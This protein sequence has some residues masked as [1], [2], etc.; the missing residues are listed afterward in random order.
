MGRHSRQLTTYTNTPH[1]KY[2]IKTPQKRLSM[3]PTNTTP[4]THN[5]HALSNHLQLAWSISRPRFWLYLGGTYLVGYSAGI[6]Q[7]TDFST[8]IFWLYLLFFLL[9]ANVFLYGINDYA[10][11][12]KYDRNKMPQLFYPGRTVLQYIFYKKIG[13]RAI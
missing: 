12:D 4:R 9:I 1:T 10:D 7:L 11:E 13:Q 2:P 5:N 8:P 3:V 6:Q